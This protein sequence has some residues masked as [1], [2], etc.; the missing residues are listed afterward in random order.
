MKK[1]DRIYREL[2]NEPLCTWYISDEYGSKVMI[3]APSLTIKSLINGCSIYFTFGKDSNKQPAIFHIGTRIFDDPIHYLSITGTNHYL[4][5]HSS[6]ERIMNSESVYIHFHSELTILVATAKL[7]FKADDRTRV[8]RLIGASEN[9]YVGDFTNEV[10]QSLD[11]F[12]FSLGIERKYRNV[13][14]IETAIVEGKLTDWHLMRNY[15]YGDNDV[16]ELETE[17]KDEGGYLEHEIL[18][19][20]ESTFRKQ[21]FKN[22]TIPHKKNYRE[23]TDILAFSDFGIFLIETK[24]MSIYCSEKDRSMD[25]KVANLQNQIS[26]AINQLIGASKKVAKNAPIHDSTKREIV[27]NKSFIPHCIVIVSELLPFGDWT[28]IEMKIF[29]SMVENDIMLH[30]MDSKEFIKYVRVSGMNKDNLDYYL[31]KRIEDFVSCKSIMMQ[32]QFT[33]P[34]I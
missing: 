8:L 18:A 5:E 4:D 19:M 7:T 25:R 15:V 29:E 6:L 28:K 17:S 30:V 31:M 2:L 12:D 14:K 13:E 26:K 20:L 34:Q 11:C 10:K 22:P 9:L 23:L 21:I 33:P 32:T 27:F 16:S 1:E 24:A 3:K